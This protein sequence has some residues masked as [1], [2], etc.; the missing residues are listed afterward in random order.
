MANLEDEFDNEIDL[1][2]EFDR[3]EAIDAAPLSGPEEFPVE[4]TD[5]TGKRSPFA[6]QAAPWATLG[7]ADVIGGA[8]GAA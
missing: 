7:L 4:D 6:Q 5:K 1:D 2:A 8:A 3:E